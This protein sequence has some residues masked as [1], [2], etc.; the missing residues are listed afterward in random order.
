MNKLLPL[1]AALLLLTGSAA[2]LLEFGQQ[3]GEAA[4]IQ[5]EGTITPSSSSF[6]SGSITPEKV[7]ELVYQARD[8]D[9]V[10]FEWNVISKN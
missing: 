6:Q 4:V 7:R 5:L 3:K 10:I 8:A 2:G 1:T 9:A